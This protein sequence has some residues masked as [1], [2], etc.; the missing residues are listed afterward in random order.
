MGS[1]DKLKQRLKAYS[2]KHGRPYNQ[3]M[4]ALLL[5]RAMVR[6]AQEPK[7]HGHLTFKGGMVSVRCYGSSRQTIDIDAVLNDL[8]LDIGLDFAKSAMARGLK[9][10]TWFVYETQIDLVTQNEYGGIRLQYRAGLGDSPPTAISRSMIVNI[11]IGV[12]DPIT[13]G[14]VLHVVE[15]IVHDA[16]ISWLVYPPETIFSEKIHSMVA[17]GDRNSRSKDVFDLAHY[18]SIVNP[19]IVKTAILNTFSYRQMPV[20]G[21]IAET[22]ANIDTSVLRLGWRSATRDIPGKPDFD[23]EFSRIIEFL[24]SAGL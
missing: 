20:P 24:K 7:L 10:L 19:N 16:A 22:L 2:E 11:D 8:S 9:D 18:T 5:E 21:S 13:P 14:P 23:A 1:L 17:N 4:Q 15:A 6:L 12:G 3:A